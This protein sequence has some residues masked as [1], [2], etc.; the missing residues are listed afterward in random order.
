[1]NT[2]IRRAART[3]A[4]YAIL[5][6]LSACSADSC[7]CDGFVAQDFPVDKVPK[8][9]PTSG[10]VRVTSSGVTFLEDNLPALV[11]GLLPGG[12]SFCV[13]PTSLG[14]DICS[15]GDTC[16]SGD[17]GC[18]VTLT[19]D[20]A[21]LQ[22]TPPDT[23]NISMT[24]GGLDESLPMEVGGSTCLM[25]LFSA[26]DSSQP[27]T[28][29]GE[30]PVTFVIDSASP[31]NDVR[32]EI[33]DPVVDLSDVDFDIDPETLLDFLVCEGIDLLIAGQTL[34]DF[35]FNLLELFI[36][37]LLTEQIDPFLCRACDAMTPCGV[38]TTC[39]MDTGLCRYPDDT[40][41]ANALGL[42]GELQIG[43][44]LGNFT[45]KPDAAVDV[46]L[47]AA[48]VATVDTGITL[49]MRSGFDPVEGAICVP[50][51]PTIRDFT[52]PP[53]SAAVTGNATPFGQPFHFGF[54][55]HEKAL[56]SMLWSVWASGATCLNVNSEGIDLLSSAALSTLL[57]SIRQ[58]TYNKNSEAMIKIVPQTPPNVI[59]GANDVSNG[60]VN[61]PLMTIDWK[62]F[63][64]HM[65]AFAQDR[66][67]RLTTIRMDLMLPIAVESDGM[68]NITPIIGDLGAAFMNQRVIDG[69][70][71]AEDPQMVLDLIPTLIG[72]ALPQLTGSLASA[73]TLPEFFGFE[74]EIPQ[75]NITSVDNNTSIAIF[76][77]LKIAGMPVI[78]RAETAI[79]SHEVDLSGRTPGGLIK[80]VV[81]LEVM[82]FG[83]GLSPVD[84]PTDVEYSVRVDKG[85]WSVFGKGAEI[86]V[87]DPMLMLP[88]RHKVE[89]RA[90]YA[91][92]PASA[93]PSPAAIEVSIDWEAPTV[94]IDRR[95]AIVSFLTED[96][97]DSADDLQMRTKIVDG[98]NPSQ[99]SEWTAV[100]PMDLD[101]L[102][103]ELPV[104][105]RLDVEVRDRAGNVGADTQTITWA[106][107]KPA[108]SARAVG[109][110]GAGCSSTGAQPTS[111]FGLL[112]LALGLGVMRRRRRRLHA[113]S[114]ALAAVVCLGACKCGE[115]ETTPTLT[116]EPACAAPSQCID[117]QCV[118]VAQCSTDDDCEDGEECNAGE[119]ISAPS[120]EE[121]CD[122]ADGEYA[123]CGD[124]SGCQCIPYCD[125]G[126]DDGEYCCY[127]SNSCETLPD[128]CADTMCELGF[129]PVPTG[130]ASADPTTCAVA[131]GACE[132][133]ELPPLDIGW[134]GHYA[135]IDRNAGTTAIAVY[136]STYGDLMVGSIDAA[137][138]IDWQFVDGVPANGDI[139]GSLNG[140][141]GGIADSG[142]N[143][144]RYTALAVDDAGAVYVFYRDQDRG[145]LK[146]ATAPGPAGPYDI[147]DLD[148]DGDV[149]YWASAVHAN[150]RVHVVYVAY[151]APDPAGGFVTE[152]RHVSFD[153]G[154]SPSDPTATWTSVASAPAAHPCGADC[155]DRNESCV[156]SIAACAPESNDCPDA[157]DAGT[158][159]YQ[160]TCQDVYAEPLQG[161]LRAVGTNAQLTA[162]SNGLLVVYY[163]AMQSSAA[164]SR[165][166]GN[167]WSAPTLLGPGTG[168]W[169]GGMAD[170]SD[171][172][173]LAYMQRVGDVP[174]L[175]YTDVTAG[176]T[177]V[178]QDG[179]R[180]TADWWL[181]TDIGEDVDVRVDGSGAVNVLFNDATSHE[182]KLATRAAGGGWSVS[183]TATPGMPYS[184]A[185]GFYAAMLRVADAT[186]NVEFTINN[187][188]D[189]TTGVPLLN[190]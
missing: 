183:T 109:T 133:Q 96:L 177:E 115:D 163:D 11:N 161:Y 120:C 4:L 110:S 76:A 168:P 118:L 2:S 31:F 37:P 114:I 10:E 175:T 157:C 57:P 94:E 63:D 180:D 59:L 27:A 104:R 171:N 186:L 93:D 131:A 151:V 174:Q 154:G 58:L 39:D 17:P 23:L 145:V 124:D 136:N 126:C 68:G 3:V 125:K 53:L 129:G 52:A 113:P 20:D 176:T 7:G 19:I 147:S 132:C 108:P 54:G 152:L 188:V 130:D 67:T 1:M 112:L 173:H 15:N 164:W 50:A 77:N 34:R 184:G 6:G 9:I 28:I 80:P 16:S 101:A 73:I 150:G 160:G 88:G 24:I 36:G 102:A 32:I 78:Q 60:M 169:I 61:D 18:E 100:T 22:P 148:T 42:S 189:P 43:S 143:V 13:P 90:R 48:D 91:G 8:T 70:L 181:V 5:F 74:L 165:F 142:E 106:A 38:G 86:A 64:I 45:E 46:T 49:G 83:G 159:C 95:D 26:A 116:C 149:G 40:C 190:E 75:Q 156:V 41:V 89:V 84:L 139:E 166:D 99:W 81:N 47:R 66:W 182:L 79:V 121:L 92:E 105:F 155:A 128:P 141:R 167:A 14:F 51:D 69:E 87:D 82:P 55:L 25:N 107:P 185:H 98:Q 122:C 56:E 33:G 97:L 21:Q 138:N 134:H 127:E 153:A 71:I 137:L 140:P 135:A 111:A 162:T 119:C 12:L 158:M 146:Y 30:F 170:A 29:Q 62:D 85:V 72:V 103:N 187:Q 123:Q 144:G 178:I 179:I 172:I 44:V 35:A 65:Y 117:G